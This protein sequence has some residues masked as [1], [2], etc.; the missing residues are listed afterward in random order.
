MKVHFISLGCKT[1][2]YETN[3]MEQSFIKKGYEIVSKEEKAD[4][5]IVNTCSVTNIA[6]RKSRQMLRR[7]KQLN[8]DAIIVASGCYAQVAKKEIEKIKEVDLILGINEK[9]NIVEIIED[10][11]KNA[12]KEKNKIDNNKDSNNDKNHNKIETKEVITDVMHHDR[13]EEFGITTYTELNRAVI[14]IQD[15]CDRFCTYCI[16]PY[17]RGK[18]RSRNPENIIAEIKEVAKKGIKE[19]VLTGIHI[20]S[21]GKDFDE[22]K[23]KELRKKYNY[24]EDY[25]KFNPKDDLHT[26]GFRFIELLEQINKIDEIDRVRLGSIEPKLINE[27]FVKRLVKLDKICNHFHLSLQS[28]CDETLD[29]MNRRYTTKE[30]ENSCKLLR[31][32][33]KD[34][35]LTTDII[36]GFPSETDKEFEETYK[37]LKKIKFYKMHIFK[38]SPRKGT[39]AASLSR[40]IDGNIKEKRSQELI[41]LSNKNEQEY[42]EK[43]VGQD[44]EVLFEEEKDGIFKGHT[45]NYIL[46]Y[47]KTNKNIENKLVK[48]KCIGAEN[49]HILTEM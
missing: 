1:N 25:E 29:R 44:V 3:A 36:V 26:G 40:Q 41:K 34:L 18:V 35:M 27:D 19:V 48:V 42:N 16:I 8:P 32:N 47:C 46:A 11:I 43:Y 38:Y 17:A 23:V 22:D 5:Y 13:Y 20:A 15:G 2:Q 12:N 24:S 49:D 45:K 37:F 31:D 4:I 21:Y 14:K 33:F 30:F 28:G 9:N 10:Y 39:V 7:A 6:E